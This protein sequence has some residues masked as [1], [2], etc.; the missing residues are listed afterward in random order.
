MKVWILSSK[1]GQGHWSAAIAL[2]ER[3]ENQGHEVLVEDVIKV[4]HPKSYKFIY[5]FFKQVI[6][7]SST[8]YNFVNHFGRDPKFELRK[9]KKLKRRYEITNPDLILCTWSGAARILGE[10]ET[11]LV[12]YIT[13]FGVHPG[14][15]AKGV[16]QYIVADK[17]VKDKLITYGVPDYIIEIL[18][19]P[20][21]S[22]FTKRAVNQISPKKI[23]IMGGGLGICPWVDEPL[24]AL[25]HYNDI[26]ITIITGNN[27]HLFKKLKRKY[28]NIN[29]VGF[30][31][32]MDKYLKEASIVIS[33][34]GGVSLA[35]SIAVGVPFVAI[36]PSF[37]HELENASYIETH[38][39]G[40]VVRKGE[41]I[42]DT[43]LET[44]NLNNIVEYNEQDGN[45]YGM[46]I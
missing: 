8:L 39:C 10:V 36:Y 30:T 3:Y 43:V 27:K 23:L 33:K 21:K 34:P 24:H 9:S 19:I 16:S 29:V 20:V 40:A 17:T 25:A 5:S 45:T 31:E 1:F 42:T 15:I 2:K 18:G 32:D 14:W 4:I 37:E 46:A 7:R 22:K 6:T 41:S 12:V 35:E 28:P 13:D 38:H 26:D 44:M 11:E